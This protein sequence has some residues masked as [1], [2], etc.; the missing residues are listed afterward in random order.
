MPVTIHDPRVLNLMALLVGTDMH[1]SGLYLV[2]QF[3]HELFVVPVCSRV[4]I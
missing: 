4:L 2:L 3:S 1:L